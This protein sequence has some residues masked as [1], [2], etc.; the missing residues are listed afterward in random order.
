MMKIGLKNTGYKKV[1]RN[2]PRGQV[3]R[4]TL[5]SSNASKEKQNIS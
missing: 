3:P 2:S 1:D 5:N 4:P